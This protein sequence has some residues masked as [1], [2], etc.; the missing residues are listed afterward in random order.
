MANGAIA[1][2]ENYSIGNRI[3]D[4]QHKELFRLTNEFYE[5]CLMGGVITK[6]YFFNTV[7][8]AINYIRTHFATE[9][10]ILRKIEYPAFVT[11]KRMHEEF[12]IKVLEQVRAFEHEDMPNPI[13]FIRF[14]M[15]WIMKHIANADKLYIPYLAKLEQ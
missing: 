1:W 2:N 14:L 10:E 4:D 15:E 13:G 8:G 7:Q 12:I 5:G 11:H 9:E 6:V 3:I